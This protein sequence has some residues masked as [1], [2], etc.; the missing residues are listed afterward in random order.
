MVFIRSQYYKNENVTENRIEIKKHRSMMP[1]PLFEEVKKSKKNSID[2][3]DKFVLRMILLKKKFE[4][5]Q[6]SNNGYNF[7]LIIIPRH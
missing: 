6:H 1:K 7:Y 5:V 4:R 2:L 3:S